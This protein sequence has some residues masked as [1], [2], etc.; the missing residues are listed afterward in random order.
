MPF[1]EKRKNLTPVFEEFISK[2]IGVVAVMILAIDPLPILVKDEEIFN[3]IFPTLNRGFSDEFI[4]KFVGQDVINQYKTTDIYIN[5]YNDIMLQ[6]KRFPETTEVVQYQ[7]VDT[8][9]INRILL[10]KHLLNPEDIPV[11]KLFATNCKFCKAYSHN[12]L[13]MFFSDKNTIRSKRSY[14]GRTF[15]TFCKSPQ[16]Y[17]QPFDEAFISVFT[18]SDK[19]YYMEHNEKLTD[20]EIN[21]ILQTL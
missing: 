21:L 1:S 4:D 15:Q 3:R 13:K 17:N 14:D 5:H 9:K 11:V 7:Y 10:Q 12:G 19:C 20:S 2:A 16:K 8:R 6:E 18:I